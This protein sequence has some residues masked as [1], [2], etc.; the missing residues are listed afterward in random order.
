MG[1]RLWKKAIKMTL[2]E[3]KIF[4]IFT[5]IYTILIFLTS[6]FIETTLSA[7]GGFLSNYFILIFFFTSLILS[8]L[9]AW[10]IVSR[11]RRIFATLKCIGY[12]NGN[13]NSLVVGNILF[14]TLMGFIIVIEGLLHYAAI[15]TYIQSANYLTNIPIILISLLPVVLTFGMFLLVQI[16][17]IIL[18]NRKVLKVRPVIALKR[19]GQ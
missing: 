9:Y 11:N 10:L 3:K 8:L 13:I 4:V 14:T 6:F 15:V 19:V 2:R 5:G 12:T 7:G 18:A 16:I 17:A 1:F